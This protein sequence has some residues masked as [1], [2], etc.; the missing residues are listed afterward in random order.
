[1]YVHPLE[2]PSCRAAIGYGDRKT[3]IADLLLALDGFTS[4]IVAHN[5]SLFAAF[6]KNR[7]L[8]STIRHHCQ[9][10]IFRYAAFS[11][12]SNNYGHAGVNGISNEWVHSL[13][14]E[15]IRFT[16][17]WRAIGEKNKLAVF[18]P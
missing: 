13:C 11:T 4:E 16:R 8:S 5:L 3:A 1:M 2:W 6:P 7:N 9:L 17:D 14:R 10:P 12:R 15:G 18:Q